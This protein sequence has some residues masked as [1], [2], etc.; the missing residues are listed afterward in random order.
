MGVYD[1]VDSFQFAIWNIMIL[2]KTSTRLLNY[3]AHT[4]P[5]HKL[6]SQSNLIFVNDCTEI[7]PQQEMNHDPHAQKDT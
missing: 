7:M 1:Y 3:V 5:G 2:L 4:R 6:A